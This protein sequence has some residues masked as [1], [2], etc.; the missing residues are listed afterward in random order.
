MT[1]KSWDKFHTAP[2]LIK[3][4]SVLSAIGTLFFLFHTIAQFI[5]EK[6]INAGTFYI[7]PWTQELYLNLWVALPLFFV[8]TGTAVRN[9]RI[10]KPLIA[11]VI[12][13]GVCY[14]LNFGN[15][16]DWV[17]I[18][19][20]QYPQSV[21][22]IG[23]NVTWIMHIA[24]KKKSVLD[25]LKFIWLF[26]LTYAFVIPRFIRSGHE[27]GNFFL[28]SMFVFPAMMILGLF[29]FFKKQKQPYEQTS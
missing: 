7:A 3:I 6:E 22:L 14:L 12:L 2:I 24:K 20:L 29:Y 26:G 5:Y 8:I 4:L 18:P 25:I 1:A 10:K 27:S 9:N 11:F 19:H 17:D 28:V 21:A 13:F 16:Y 23:I 15:T